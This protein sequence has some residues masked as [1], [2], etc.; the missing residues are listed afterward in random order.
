[1]NLKNFL[2]SKFL[3]AIFAVSLHL[4][5]L[6][7]ITLSI[8]ILFFTKKF[9]IFFDCSLPESLKFLCVEQSL[10]SKLSGSPPPGAYACLIKIRL[11]P[12]FSISKI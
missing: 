8:G 10:I 1:M 3:N 7:E 12:F 9:P 11:P 5:H 6:L 4:H 2:V